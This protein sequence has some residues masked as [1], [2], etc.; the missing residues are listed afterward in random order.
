MKPNEST[1]MK[2]KK[3]RGFTLIEL[4]IT[5]AIIG[6]L[7]AIAYPSYIQYIVRANRS[8][9]QSFMFAV[10]NKQ[11][12]YLLDAR[13]YAASVSALNLTQPAELSGKYLVTT[14]AVN[15]DTPP[16]YTV[17]ATPQGSQASQDTKCATLTLS[18]AGAK[19]Q[20]GSATAVS[21]CW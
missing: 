20:S 9:A 8:A 17:T 18:S 6:I 4:M 15:T 2:S 1:V 14:T 21:D 10:A 19:S 5:V 3:N 16:T 11:E 7:S 13:S 12:Q